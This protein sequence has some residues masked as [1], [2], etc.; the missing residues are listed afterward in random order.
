[1]LNYLLEGIIVGVLLLVIF[2]IIERVR[3]A[4]GKEMLIDRFVAYLE[5]V[6]QRSAPKTNKEMDLRGCDLPDKVH[7]IELYFNDTKSK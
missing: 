4:T 1:M 7:V 2:V 6:Y 3:I 5:D